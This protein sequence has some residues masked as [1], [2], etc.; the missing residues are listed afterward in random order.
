[1]TDARADN[2]PVERVGRGT[3]ASLRVFHVDDENAFPF[4]YFVTGIT[5]EAR[6]LEKLRVIVLQCLDVHIVIVQV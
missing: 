3:G 4:V 5:M 2:R 6:G 1:M